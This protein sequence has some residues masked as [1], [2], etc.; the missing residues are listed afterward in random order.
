MA[1]FC[2][3]CTKKMGVDPKKNEL[4]RE[5]RGDYKYMDLCEGCGWGYFNE[6]GKRIGDLVERP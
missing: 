5:G 4:S 1:D 2:W 6:Q 3:E